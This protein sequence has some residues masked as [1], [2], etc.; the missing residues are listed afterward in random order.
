VL[1]KGY[2]G[3][4]CKYACRPGLALRSPVGKG[5][6]IA[7][8]ISS[9][10]V[11]PKVNFK[12]S[13]SFDCHVLDR[14]TFMDSNNKLLSSGTIPAQGRGVYA[15]IYSTGNLQGTVLVTIKIQLGAITNT[16]YAGCYMPK[17]G[18]K[19]IA[20]VRDRDEC[21]L[22]NGGCDKLTKCKNAAPGNVCGDGPSGYV[23]DGKSGCI[24]KNGLEAPTLPRPG[25][26][27][28]R[29]LRRQRRTCVCRLGLTLTSASPARQPLA[30]TSRRRVTSAGW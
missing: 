27:R 29:A 15:N 17:A 11:S 26:S 12:L 16:F 21:A 3:V 4:G 22:N 5:D 7:I 23:G 9:Q 19:A 24:N 13:A 20:G 18:Y 2:Q 28:S 10:N 6:K 1:T 8:D 30:S 25:S 14:V